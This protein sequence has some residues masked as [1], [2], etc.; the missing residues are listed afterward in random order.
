MMHHQEAEPAYY[1]ILSEADNPVID[2]SV[3]EIK[4]F[5][6]YNEVILNEPISSNK[7]IETVLSK[8]MSVSQEL[9]LAN[10]YNAMVI[11]ERT[12]DVALN[13]KN[14]YLEWLTLRDS[15]K[16]DIESACQEKGIE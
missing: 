10:D 4:T 9:K 7:I 14:R 16:S 2:N 15:L 1:G 8:V 5:Y 13:K 12:D 11:A 6:N 3:T